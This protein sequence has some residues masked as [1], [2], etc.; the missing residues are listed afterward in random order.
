[1]V[2][3]KASGEHP[4]EFMARR[5]VKKTGGKKRKRKGR[6]VRPLRCSK[7]LTPL[8]SRGTTWT[9]PGGGRNRANE[10]EGISSL[11]GQRQE[12]SQRLP[13]HKQDF[14]LRVHMEAPILY[15]KA[16]EVINQA[17]KLLNETYV[18]PCY[19]KDIFIMTKSKILRKLGFQVTESWQTVKKKIGF[20]IARILVFGQQTSAV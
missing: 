1:M 20:R 6:R 9:H 7:E 17:I 18:T 14:K 4:Q 3:P 12:Y 8:V 19:E 13:L 15:A 2:S 5:E 10:Q 11:G 16:F